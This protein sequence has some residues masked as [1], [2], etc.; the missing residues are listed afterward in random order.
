MNVQVWKKISKY[1]TKIE[2]YIAHE[3]ASISHYFVQLN[4][5]FKVCIPSITLLLM[6]T[7]ILDITLHLLFY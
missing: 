4:L 5:N 2:V 6:Y 3:V 1:F 7:S